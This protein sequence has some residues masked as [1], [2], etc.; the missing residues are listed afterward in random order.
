MNRNVVVTVVAVAVLLV[1]A[2]GAVYAFS[3]SEE[4]RHTAHEYDVTDIE[5]DGANE[6]VWSVA[7]N[8]GEEGN[9]LVGYDIT[10]GSV[11][12]TQQFNGGNA[13]AVDDGTVYVVAGSSLEAYDIDTG[14]V[15]QVTLL[16]EPAGDLEYD[17][18]RDWLWL[19]GGFGTVWAVDPSTGETVFEHTEHTDDEGIADLSIQGDHV[20]SVLTWEP[21]VVVYDIA[22]NESVDAPHADALVENEDDN[23]ASV[24]LTDDGGLIMGGDTDQIALVDV[25]TGEERLSYRG[26]GHAWGVV[27][28]EYHEERDVIA[29]TDLDGG[30]AFYDVDARE[31]LGSHDTGGEAVPA[32]DVDVTN[33]RLWVG[34]E[35]EGGGPVLGL[36]MTFDEATPTPTPT[37][38]PTDTPTPTPTDPT[39]TPTPTPDSGGDG[40]PGIGILGTV[41]ALMVVG[42]LMARRR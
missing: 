42:Y 2:A 13:L 18:E 41:L 3:V 40:S 38:T 9:Q 6:M 1:V 39:P 20:A 26:P 34:L 25:E 4:H 30:V 12:V 29:S 32:A 10:S 24:E 35:G 17:A 36:S 7:H 22:A 8:P 33:D 28:L 11:S 5:Y 19:A 21:E 31:A 14:E 27:Q 37:P 16:S 23:I 15:E